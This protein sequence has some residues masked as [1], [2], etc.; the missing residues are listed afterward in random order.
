MV[1]RKEI[2]LIEEFEGTVMSID[3]EPS[4]REDISNEQ[5]HIEIAPTDK[6]LLKDS[7][8]GRFHE[9]IRITDKT[10][11]NLV[12]E[13]S[14]LDRYMQEIEL[15]HKDAKNKETYMEVFKLMMGNT[16]LFKRKK[17]GKAYGGFEAH[18]YFCPVT[19]KEKQE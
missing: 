3:V 2:E 12:P 18:K 7:K 17:L 16:Y 11:N 8:T 10:E 9:W 13:G 4:Q 14:I 1:K 15:I 19:L 6:E 5:I